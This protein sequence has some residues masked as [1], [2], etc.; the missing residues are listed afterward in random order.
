MFDAQKDKFEVVTLFDKKVLFC[1]GRIDKSTVPKDL[2]VYSVRH[3][4]NMQGDPVQLANWILVNHWGDVI[5]KEPFE[6]EE[7]KIES[8]V[9]AR[10]AFVSLYPQNRNKTYLG[11]TIGTNGYKD[12][13][14]EVDWDYEGYEMTLKEYLEEE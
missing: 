4:D 10:E 2:Y 7:N 12:I 13:D 9:T 1:C 5:S 11:V 3:D 14:S 8:I 6:L